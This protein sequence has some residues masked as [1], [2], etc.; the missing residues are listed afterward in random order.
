[1]S[2]VLNTAMSPK[3]AYLI[4]YR[5]L[6]C[7]STDQLV[8]SVCN[9][10]G[11][12]LVASLSGA[13]C[14]TQLERILASL[15]NVGIH[16]VGRD[17]DRRHKIHSKGKG[18]TGGGGGGGNHAHHSTALRSQKSQNFMQNSDSVGLSASAFCSKINFEL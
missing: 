15:C 16:A 1:M 8:S 7:S 14:I 17:M 6:F 4:S 3:S 13:H 11:S 12:H 10:F 9:L 2:F 18:S 5:T